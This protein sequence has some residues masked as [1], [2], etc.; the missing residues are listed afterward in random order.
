MS[1]FETMPKFKSWVSLTAGK[2]Q[3]DLAQN[4]AIISARVDSSSGRLGD[5][6]VV[7]HISP[8]SDATAI[9]SIVLT[10]TG[11]LGKMLITSKYS[12]VVIF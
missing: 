6:T 1:S 9:T 3:V 7:A 8:V 5:L 10:D 2:Q 12:S 11:T 4:P